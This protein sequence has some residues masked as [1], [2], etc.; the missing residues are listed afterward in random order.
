MLKVLAVVAIA[1]VVSAT[2]A[3]AQTQQTTIITPD[4]MIIC[5]QMGSVITCH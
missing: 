1:V 4:G 2:A 5:T 3:L